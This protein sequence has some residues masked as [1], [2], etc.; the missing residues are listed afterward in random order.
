ME[1][2]QIP[3]AVAAA[4]AGVAA[5][6][7]MHPAAQIFGP[8]VRRGGRRGAI[9]LTF[10]DGPNPAVTPALLDL[11][12]REC[13][14]ATFFLIGRFVRECP[15]LAREISKR[16]HLLGNHTDS[17]PDLIWLSRRKIGEELERCQQAIDSATGSTPEWMRPPY[18]F[19]G[20][21]LGGVLRRMGL[22]GPVMWTVS[23]RDWVPQPPARLERRLQPVSGGDIVLLHDGDYRHLGGDRHQ[24]LRALAHW[25]PRWRDAGIECVTLDQ[26]FAAR[27]PGPEAMVAGL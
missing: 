26:F 18:G 4:G 5:F 24:T 15:T 14:R 25:L 6:G 21:Q 10:D 2:W 20:P 19:R 22:R 17:H 9:A 13:S 8:T 7:A 16:G 23:A 12:D 1:M 11:L 3:A 27:S